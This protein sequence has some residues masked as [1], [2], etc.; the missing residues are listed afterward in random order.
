M[1]NFG[2]GVNRLC[3]EVNRS[4]CWG[5]LLFAGCKARNRACFDKQLIKHPCEVLFTACSFMR[6]WAGLYP[7]DMQ[8][9]IVAGAESM[10]KAVMQV[11]GRC[12]REQPCL[13]IKESDEKEEEREDE[14]TK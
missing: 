9:V 11:I 14:Q 7:G 8:E 1:N 5:W 4:I 3:L 2:F 12:A 10:L 13:T 6:Y